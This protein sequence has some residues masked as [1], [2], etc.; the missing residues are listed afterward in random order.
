MNPHS[1]EAVNN[2]PLLLFAIIPWQWQLPEACFF[3]CHKQTHLRLKTCS[4]RPPHDTA[5]MSCVGWAL[6]LGKQHS[7]TL[8]S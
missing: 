5:N 6:S 3:V 1:S 2:T 4:A 8:K 7:I